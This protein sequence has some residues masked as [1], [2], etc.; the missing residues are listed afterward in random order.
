MKIENGSLK[1]LETSEFFSSSSPMFNNGVRLHAM[2]I[3]RCDHTR[4]RRIYIGMDGVVAVSVGVL[5]PATGS[6][7]G[8]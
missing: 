3:F 4:I 6:L 1:R 8:R 2:K 5:V 7:A